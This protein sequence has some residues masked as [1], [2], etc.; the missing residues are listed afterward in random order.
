MFAK[1][2]T[3]YFFKKQAKKIFPYIDI[4]EANKGMARAI[5]K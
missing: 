5:K 4:G 3:F 2:R 1:F